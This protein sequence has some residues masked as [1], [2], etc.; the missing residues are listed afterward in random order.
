MRYIADLHIHSCYSRATSSQSHLETL[1]AW[2]KIKGID[3]LATG[4]FTHPKWMKEIR[5]SLTEAEPGFYRLNNK[6]LMLFEDLKSETGST[7]FVL[8]V[9]I[10]SIYKKNGKVRKVHSLIFAPD[11]DTAEKIN[12]KLS[13]IGNINS[14]GRPILGLDVKNMLDMMLNISDKIVM[15]PAHIWTPWFSLLGSK[16]GFDSVEECFEDLSPH[17]FALETG[18]SSDPP[19]NWCLSALDRYSLVSNS[20]AHSPEKLG[21]EANIFDCDLD[22]FSM[23][24]ALKNKKGFWGT[25]E[26]FPEEGKY[27]FD[28][29]RKCNVVL[30]PSQSMAPGDLCPVC[31]KELTIGVMNRVFKLADRKIP[32]KPAGSG[33]FKNLFP[34]REVIA[35]TLNSSPTSKKTEKEYAR[36]LNTYGNEFDILCE[37]PL[38]E[39]SEDSNPLLKEALKR[40]REG[41][42]IKSAG[43][44]GE[45]G[46]IKI[47]KPEDR[48]LVKGQTEFLDLPMSVKPESKKSER[49]LPFEKKEEFSREKIAIAH[50]LNEG[51]Q[52]AVESEASALIL[53]AGPGTGKTRTLVEK[54]NFLL[55]KGVVPESVLAVT[56]TNKAAT[57]MKERLA[58]LSPGLSDRVDVMTLHSFVLRGLRTEKP[59]L[60][61]VD[62]K[63][64]MALISWLFP[65]CS[66]QEKNKF[67]SLIGHYYRTGV[68]ENEFKDRFD[69]YEQ[70]LKKM[71]Q[72]DLEGVIK[73]GVD[74]F[75]SEK[76]TMKRLTERYTAVF[77]D[78]FQDLDAFQYEFLLKM[79]RDGASF[80]VIGDPNQSIYGFRGADPRFFGL[81]E[82]D[83]KA[84]K[85][86]LEINYRNNPVILKS[87]EFFVS[88]E[89]PK[90]R[91]VNP[92]QFRIMWYE[93][94]SEAAEADF[95]VHSIEKLV[96]GISHFSVDSGRIEENEM[97][98][99]LS[100]KSIAVLVRNR[101]KMNVLK[102]SLKA[103]GIPFRCIGDRNFFTEK[104]FDLIWHLLTLI[105]NPSSWGSLTEILGALKFS[106]AVM[107]SLFGQIHQTG[108]GFDSFLELIEFM[109]KHGSRSDLSCM[110]LRSLFEEK[111]RFLKEMEGL[112]SILAFFKKEIPEEDLRR[113]HTWISEFKEFS[114]VLEYVKANENAGYDE[115]IEAVSLMTIH[116]SKG[117]EFDAVFIIG[118]E[119]EKGFSFSENQSSQEEEKRLFYVGMTRAR[120]FLFLSM[121]NKRQVYGECRLYKRSRWVDLI[122]EKNIT[123][124]K[125]RKMCKKN[126]SIQME[127]F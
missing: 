29:H 88:K 45:Y 118:C 91:P 112:R 27:H 84:E 100:F 94:P 80:C 20:D 60:L 26:F 56:F 15:I 96:G 59:D 36:L 55:K 5:E 42:V 19:M 16:S 68:L 23:F 75:K 67:A 92:F 2:A 34:L 107:Q 111:I 98:S 86:F 108:K 85:I 37:I 51:Q 10:S 32:Q 33:N 25:Y 123:V 8:C 9:E 109:E 73:S 74:L 113:F 81:F 121:S 53:L 99:D 1:S 49:C 124:Y 76:D 22:Y 35:D 77:V 127:L 71:N 78:E 70:Y 58:Q 79:K 66:K 13:Q 103:S 50:S 106:S 54:I 101:S 126:N 44:D 116:A 90:L 21:R 41:E 64:R 63:E 97:T 3:V 30:D 24:D 11:L 39:F 46:I 61:L 105:Q 14:D 89:T 57:E 83:F 95:V 43:Y 120:N 12:L 72:M 62:E 87:A 114:E 52:K 28:G 18:L 110:A 122:P 47:F 115:K 65:D 17:I 125:H 6:T 48:V 7:R 69:R 117:L 93:A 104:P 38:N 82:K 31:G 4:D 40:M 102:D 119:E